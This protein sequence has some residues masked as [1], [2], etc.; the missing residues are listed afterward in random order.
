[1]PIIQTC[2]SP[3][4]YPLFEEPETIVV[5][6]DIF[7][8]TSAI[9]TALDNGV[10]KMI[11]VAGL[12]EARKYKE[13]GYMV[14]A[15]RNAIKEEG[16]DLGNS[17]YDYLGDNVKGKTIAISTTN[18][19][20]AIEAAKSASTIV[21]GSFLNISSVAEWIIMQQKNVLILCSGWKNK[22]NMEDSLFAGALSLA[23]LKQKEYE[24]ACD[25][26]IAAGHLYTLAKDN[27]FAFL[28]YSSHRKRLK[29]LHL[30]KDITYCLTL[31][32]MTTIPIYFEG[33]LVSLTPE[34]LMQMG[35][36]SLVTFEKKS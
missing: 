9:C 21:I 32:T 15:E 16:F 8:A 25:S 24:T 11:P 28:E 10:T 34:V 17:P 5:V 12:D 20:Q 18:G 26:T 36:E 22:Y 19:T 27:M 31:N 23:L 4:L 14:A 29:N 2:Y 3:A 1:M 13:M 35:E 6:V 30:E 7:R 33:G